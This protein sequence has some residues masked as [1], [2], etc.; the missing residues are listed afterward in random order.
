MKLSDIYGYGQLFGFSGMDGKTD[1]SDDFI[2]MLMRQP[3]EIRFE[4]PEPLSVHIPVSENCKFFAVMSDF[5]LAE[6]E[7][8]SIAVAWADAYTMIGRSEI[9][10]QVL[11]G[12][13][14]CNA[15]GETTVYRYESRY[16]G[17]ARNGA[18][19]AVSYG[20]SAA[21]AARRAA[22]GLN[23]ATDAVLRLRAGYYECLPPCKDERYEKL[24]Y[25]AL[26]VNKVNVYS[27]AGGIPVRYTTPDRVPHKHMWLWDSVFH[28]LAWAQYDCN[29]AQDAVAAVLSQQREDGFIPHRMSC[30]GYADNMTQPPVLAYGVWN[31]YKVSGDRQFLRICADKL[32]K[33]L[34][35]DIANRDS[36]GNGLLEWLI[37]ENEDCRSG[38][39][40]MDNSPRFDEALTLDAVDFSVF[41]A[42]DAGCLAKIFGELGEVEKAAEWNAVRN[43]T[44]DAVNAMLWC[45]EDG[46][47]YDLKTDG[48]FSKVA[49]VASFLPLFAGIAP[50]DRAEKLVRVLTDKN[51]FMTDLPVASVSKENKA[52]G[53]DMWRGAVWLNYNYMIVC[54][55]RRYGYSSLARQLRDVTLESVNRR[56]LATGSIFEFYDSENKRVPFE[57][58]RKG[59]CPKVPDWRKKVHSISD[60]N[61]S[62]C[63][64]MLMIQNV[65]YEC[66]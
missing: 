38:E 26:S 47:Y 13:Y 56:Y 25:K 52:F 28:A 54:G 3:I 8:K 12:R 60:Y 49:S 11:Q 41:L 31:V 42:N 48:S 50:E 23:Q 17:F 24:Y 53:Q 15:E 65:Y 20:R 57:L 55:L 5:L 22:D 7:G 19:F 40:G 27:P 1:E 35:W 59:A 4:L 16:V 2:A 34:R 39:S 37:E 51:K 32:E 9:P 14:V 44:A 33:Y 30:R 61:W 62:A 29:M 43:K 6:D 63:F 21:A 45:E 36:N 58:E 10:A 66:D 46:L 18:R 64:T